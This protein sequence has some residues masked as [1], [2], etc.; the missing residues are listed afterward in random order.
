MP[1]NPADDGF[2]ETKEMPRGRKAR[3]IPEIVWT[4]L[5]ESAT[6]KVAFT[7]SG[8]PDVIDQLRRDLGAAA[9]RA[10]YD[11]TVGTDKSNAKAHTLT[12]AA[13][14]RAQDNGS[15]PDAAEATAEP[16]PATAG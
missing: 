2:T 4:K 6:R 13:Q 14:H 16:E 12:F 5:E 8:S 3:A 1:A 7:K 10:K 15:A 9:V 11:V